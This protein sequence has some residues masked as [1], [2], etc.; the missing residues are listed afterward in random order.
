MVLSLIWQDTKRIAAVVAS[1]PQLCGDRHSVRVEV[2]QLARFPCVVCQAARPQVVD[3][4][5]VIAG[6]PHWNRTVHLGYAELRL[7]ES[8]LIRL[9]FT[10][11]PE[12]THRIALL[13]TVARLLRKTGVSRRRIGLLT[14]NVCSAGLSRRE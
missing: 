1:A 4:T 11:S 9:A 5:R 12:D 13:G 8:L 3:G 6:E 14:R 10:Y 2:T 7:V